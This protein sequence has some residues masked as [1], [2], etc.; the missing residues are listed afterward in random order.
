MMLYEGNTEC[1]HALVNTGCPALVGG[2]VISIVVFKILLL[3]LLLKIS[4]D[5]TSQSF[6]CLILRRALLKQDLLRII[7]ILHEMKVAD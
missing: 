2:M 5:G 3:L 7:L 6:V 4:L 1:Q